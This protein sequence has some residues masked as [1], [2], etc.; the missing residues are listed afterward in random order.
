MKTLRHLVAAIIGNISWQPPGWVFASGRVARRHRMAIACAALLLGVGTLGARRGY[1]WYAHRPKRVKVAAAHPAPAAT[2]TP[3][4]VAAKTPAPAATP[5]IAVYTPTPGPTP[6][7][8]FSV[9]VSAIQAT[10]PGQVLQPSPLNITFGGPVAPV[11]HVGKTVDSGIHMD[12]PVEGTWA[13]SGWNS[14]RNLTFTP[15]NDWPPDKTLTIWFDKGVF[16]PNTWLDHYWVYVRTPPFSANVTKFEFYQNPDDPTVKQAVAT[17]EFSQPVTPGMLEKHLSLSMTAGSPVFNT[18]AAPFKIKYDM[19]DRVAYLTSA[20]LTLPEHEDVM[21]LVIDGR[22]PDA[23]GDAVLGRSEERNVTIPDVYSGFRIESAEG[24]VI[25]AGEGDSQQ[26]LFVSTSSAIKSEDLAKSLEVWL[27]PKKAEATGKTDGNDAKTDEGDDR[28]DPQVA[29]ERT[30][31]RYA[32]GGRGHRWDDDDEDDDSDSDSEED[33]TNT[34]NQADI[35]APQQYTSAGDVDDAVL[36]AA[37]PVKF[38]VIPAEDEFSKQHTFKIAVNTDGTLYVRI[39]KGV[40]A[41]GDFKLGQDFETVLPV[42]QS[43]REIAIQGDGGVLAL[44]GERKVSVESRGVEQIEYEIARI[45]A[46]NINHL[47]SQTRGS[48]EDPTFINRSFDETNIA[49]IALEKQAIDMKDKY[50]S[51]YSTFDFSKHLGPVQDAGAPVEGLFLLHARAVDPK[52][53]KYIRG[54]DSRRFILVTD[55]GMLVKANGDGSRDVFVESIKSRAPLAG[56]RVD[57]L[58]RNG[59]PALTAISDT[60]G[61]VSFP[62]LGKPSKEREP[63][64]IVG[65]LG[66][67]VS[68]IPYDRDD[69][70]IDFSRF[71]VGG[72]QS[73]TP[74]DLD[75]FVFTERGVYRPGEEI[76]AAFSVK[77]HNWG[78]VPAGIP[79]ETEVVD[80]RGTTAQVKKIALPEGGVAEFSYQTAYESPTGD[81]TF[82]VYLEHNGKRGTLIGSTTALIKEFLPDRMKI[83]SHLSVAPGRGWMLP[84]DVEAEVTLRNL[85]GTPASD[86]RVVSK[87]TLDPTGFEFNAYP[88]YT[89]YDRLLEANQDTKWQSLDLGEQK[90][91]ENGAAKVDLDLGRFCNATYRVNF[92]A[93]GFEAEGGRSVTASSSA[94]VSPLAYVVGWKADGD[95]GY[96][97]A[98]SEHSIQLIAI[99]NTLKKIAVKDLELSVVE[100]RYVSVLRKQEGGDYEYESVPKE[101]TV[102]TQDVAISAEG[103]NYK[104]PTDKAGDYIVVVREKET[105]NCVSK[106]EFNVAGEGDVAGSLDQNADLVVKLDRKQ[107]NAGDDVEVNITAPYTGCGLIT[108]EREKVYAWQWFKADTTSTVQHVRIPKDFD[109]TGY[110]NVSYIRS[111]DSKEIYMSPLSY[112]VAPFTANKEK[113]ALKIALDCTKQA[114]PGEPL[115]ISYKTN[116]P[117]KIV[118]FAVDEGILQVTGYETPD[119]LAYYFRKQALCVQTSQI[120]DLIMPEYSKLKAAAFGGDGEAKHLNPFK[121]VT[122]KP[123]VFWSGVLDSDTTERRVCYNV[124][125]YFNGTLK[126]MAVAMAPDAVGSVSQNTLVRGPFVITPGVP[127]LAAPGDEFEVGVTVANN[128]SGSGENAAVTLTA[129]PSEHLEIVHAP[130]EPMIIPEG[131]E[132]SAVFTVRAK[133]KLGSASLTFKAETGGQ[134]SSLRSTLSVRPA[135]PRTTEVRGGTFLG[136]GA[137]VPV[138]NNLM[139]EFRELQTVVSPTPMGMAHGLDSYLH[140][141]PNGC[142]EQIT[143]GAFCRLIIADNGDFELSRQELFKQMEYTFAVERRRQNDQGGFGLWGP[144]QTPEIDFITTYVMDFLI[145][146]KASGFMPPADEFQG[147]LRYLRK[148][149]DAQP[150]DAEQARTVAYAIYLL[151]R[152]QVIT[153]NQILNLEDYLNKNEAGYWQDDL[154]GV[155]L[156]GSLAMLKKDAEGQKIIAGYHMGEYRRGGWIH[157]YDTLGADS[158]YV[159]IVSRHFPN[160]LKD[161]TP[162]DFAA[163]SDTINRGWFS[164][165]GAAYATMALKSYTQHMTTNPPA[166]TVTEIGKDNHETQLVMEGKTNKHGEFSPDATSLRITTAST[167]GGMGEFY[168]VIETGYRKDLPAKPE[169][170][171]LE[172]HREFLDDQGN[173]THTAVLGKPVKVRLT[174]RAIGKEAVTNVAIDDLLPGGFEVVDSTLKPGVGSAGC[175]YVDVREDRAVFFTTVGIDA[176]TIEYEIKP[177]NR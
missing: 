80:A 141:Y 39:R 13:W 164:T 155:Y 107:Y 7:V 154:T 32:Y 160:M 122:D 4:A 86:R 23:T 163:I 144:V 115:F 70:M 62:A 52:T 124:P 55:I 58:A 121:R 99:N 135:V 43:P 38:T 53:K 54:V 165:L 130:D 120:V 125:D 128:V 150:Q 41:L 65:W 112:G 51:N 92:Y 139:P 123:V 31:N 77:Q 151:T 90:T 166:L 25:H 73:V 8:S 129:D 146:A 101:T 76:H 96:L 103:L 9:F 71:D 21:K 84:Q 82:N 113:R 147:G 30:Y 49:R 6:Y 167:V 156:A 102:S 131:K 34:E 46:D 17:I 85:Y 177:C 22:L 136:D 5:N 134:T 95:L 174:V 106:C 18:N 75:A 148:M 100:K 133:E 35:Q 152:E 29:A 97:K 56:V 2:K 50:T 44:N 45:P 81:Y 88:E 42:P 37:K 108:I 20:P 153:T 27:L 16:T 87:I 94:L 67:D 168:Q 116:K 79:V 15:K 126:V 173:V 28:E 3:A 170:N 61:H 89:F 109:G 72:D 140:N 138:S 68:F 117:G 93:E 127:T 33:S 98:K 142:S 57:V 12:P 132:L 11:D 169:A 176:M 111:L 91:D 118:V 137:I 114:K 14:D 158:Q 60:A 64:A 110:I 161:I 104:L 83:E 63:V 145:E 162:Q 10:A 143:S 19:H 48:F 105:K 74:N 24:Q 78:T 149:A 157:F 1:D 47:V 36:K 159:T 119:P 26:V 171:G 66:N 59:V 40:K 172:V 69:R 175:D